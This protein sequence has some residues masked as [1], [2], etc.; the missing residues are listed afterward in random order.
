M[1]YSVGWNKELTY[2]IG[3][4]VDEVVDVTRR[5][6]KDWHQVLQR[7]QLIDEQHLT[8]SIAQLSLEI[9]PQPTDALK[10]R[11]VAEQ[12]EFNRAISVKQE[13]LLGRQSGK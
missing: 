7:R 1:M 2:C 10:Q 8:E 9:Q 4:S 12:Q 3:F 5:Y 13:E 6:V 11:Q